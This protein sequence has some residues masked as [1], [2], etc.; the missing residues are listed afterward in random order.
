M[1]TFG[2]LTLLLL[3]LSTAAAGDSGLR[4]DAEFSDQYGTVDSLARRAGAPVIAL[5]VGIKALPLIEKWERDL[6]TRV[7]GIRF[8]N[9]VDL[10]IDVPGDVPGTVRV[11]LDRTAATL[12]KRVPA[13]VSVL[14]D[15]ERQWANAF[16][17]DTALPNLLLFD[18]KGQLVARFRGRWTAALAEEV[19]AQVATLSPVEPRP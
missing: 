6:T 12:R 4:A 18:A 16:A 13:G 10:P 1:H 14:M 19:A 17:L 9:V 11:D 8:L 15:P 2:T 5:V 7:P 3:M